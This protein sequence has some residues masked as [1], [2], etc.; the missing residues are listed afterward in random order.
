VELEGEAVLEDDEGPLYA[1][2]DDLD[3]F[4]EPPPPEAE[5]A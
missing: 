5:E 2:L 3:F 4:E 1:G